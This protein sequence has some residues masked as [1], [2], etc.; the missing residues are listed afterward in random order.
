MVGDNYSAEWTKAAFETRGIRYTRCTT[1]PWSQDLRSQV[2]KPKSQL[3]LELLPRLQ[4]QEVQLLDHPVLIEQLAQ[5]ER[6]TRV[7]GRDTVDHPQYGHDDL[8]NVVA[9]VCDCCSKPAARAG[10]VMETVAGVES[11]GMRT[12]MNRQTWTRGL[13]PGE[14]TEETPFKVCE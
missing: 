11:F 12:W 8:A 7:G 2:A 14:E 5:L 3:Y 6:R 10:V 13:V 1:N 4:S 9:G